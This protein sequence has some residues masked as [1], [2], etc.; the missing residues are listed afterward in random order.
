MIACR[1]DFFVILVVGFYTSDTATA[2]RRTIDID[3]Y[4]SDPHWLGQLRCP[5]DY[6]IRIVSM[7]ARHN[8]NLRWCQ[9]PMSKYYTV[10]M[11]RNECDITFNDIPKYLSGS[12]L[13][14]KYSCHYL[15]L[16]LVT[17]ISKKYFGWRAT[18]QPQKYIMNEMIKN[19]QSLA[20][21]ESR[22]Y[23]KIQNED[24]VYPVSVVEHLITR[25]VPAFDGGVDQLPCYV[26]ANI[27]YWHVRANQTVEPT[28]GGVEL[29]DIASRR[30]AR[31]ST[32]GFHTLLPYSIGG[33][34][35]AS[36]NL[37]PIDDIMYTRTWARYENMVRH[38]LNKYRYGMVT[39]DVV[40]LYSV[41]V[42]ER[43]RPAAF[44]LRIRLFE[45]CSDLSE[46]SSGWI[47]LIPNE[48]CPFKECGDAIHHILN[49][50][51]P[52]QDPASD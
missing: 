25:M 3:Y 18:Q 34:H 26:S 11:N 47:R 6:T 51:I 15:L 33:S 2:L 52:H 20:D 31:P 36:Y 37:V 4:S 39:W 1:V 13:R 46:N 19:R 43:N 17:D 49:P 16:S 40:S 5:I 9:V 8:E 38:Y 35:D 14:V 7:R 27:S 44:L 41:S 12:A 23:K 29:F 42:F 21:R 50:R 10:C 28:T 32:D 30:N 48:N 22:G 45:D 24:P